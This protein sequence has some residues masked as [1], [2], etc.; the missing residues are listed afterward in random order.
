MAVIQKLRASG[1]VVGAVVVA[2]IAFVATDAIKSNGS[3]PNEDLD[4]IAQVGGENVKMEEMNTRFSKYFSQAMNQ[5]Q[6]EEQRAE[7]QEEV[8]KQA[9]DQSWADLIN[10]RTI[11]AA[12]KNSGVEITEADI[13][14]MFT[15]QNIDPIAT[16]IP[17]FQENGQYSRSRV[18]EIFRQAKRAKGAQKQGLIDFITSVK[19]QASQT[20][21]AAYVSKCLKTTTLEKEFDYI[22]SNQGHYGQ[23][24]SINYSS[25][26]DTDVKLEDKDYQEYFEEH[27]YLYTPKQ[28][29]RDIE[30]VIW[31]YLP[32]AADTASALKDAQD[33]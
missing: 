4:V 2:L 11:D 14:E 10:D 33:K 18:K 7:K 32:S 1:I 26:K 16:Q 21:Y 9:I 17:D 3:N 23:I 24:V 29:E 5:L 8:R 31:D 30:Y 6:T 20:R 15:G 28:A 27:K 22:A 25:I 19:K 12:I 13:K